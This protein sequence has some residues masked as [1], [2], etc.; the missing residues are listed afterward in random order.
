MPV[1]WGVPAAL[2]AS[3]LHYL[4]QEYLVP[5]VPVP[6]FVGGIRREEHGEVVCNT[7]ITVQR[8]QK[9]TR[10]ASSEQVAQTTTSRGV[11]SK[12]TFT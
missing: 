11:G 2:S 3:S 1:W 8:M 5:E 4:L 9:G 7:Q 6:A 10:V 12:P